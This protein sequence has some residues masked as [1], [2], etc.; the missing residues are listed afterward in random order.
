MTAFYPKRTF[1]YATISATFAPPLA[2]RSGL[3]NFLLYAFIVCFTSL[4]DWLFPGSLVSAWLTT[5]LEK[6]ERFN[7]IYNR[8]LVFR[9]PIHAIIWAPVFFIHW[10]SDW[11]TPVLICAAATSAIL[12]MFSVVHA[13][14][15]VLRPTE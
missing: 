1:V 4:C 6:I 10:A 13:G 7:A 15:L 14:L 9:V 11:E 3:K 5:N 8:G 12:I 2:E